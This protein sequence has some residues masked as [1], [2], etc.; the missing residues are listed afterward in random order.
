MRDCRAAIG[1]DERTKKQTKQDGESLSQSKVVVFAN[2]IHL[3]DLTPIILWPRM[4]EL[5]LSRIARLL[6][7]S[8]LPWPAIH[9]AGTNGK[10]SITG[11]LSALLTAAG[12]RC[13]SFTSPHLVDRWDCITINERVVQESVFRRIE[14]EVKRRN[15]SLGIGATEFELLT[16]TAFEIFS[17][18]KVDVGVVEV[19]MGGR[20]DSTNILTNVLVSIVAKIGYDHQA[21]LGD[22][23]QKIARE[24]AGIMKPAVPCVVDETNDPEVQEVFETV[25]KESHTSVSFVGAEV[26]KNAFPGLSRVFDELNVPPHQQANLSCAIAALQKV[27][28]Q[29]RPEL[30]LP[31]LFPHIPK[32]PRPG[33]LHELQL[34]PLIPR[35][36]PVLLDGAHNPQSAGVLGSYVD[37][38]LRKPDASVTW[39]I[40]ASQGKNVKELFGCMIKPGDNVAVLEF[41]PVDGMPWVRSVET[42]ALLSTVRSLPGIGQSEGFGNDI[43]SGLKWADKISMDGPLVIAGSLYLVSDILRLL[44]ESSRTSRTP[45]A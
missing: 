19:G 15:H 11:Y 23:I 35:K 17:H 42:S 38:N 33:R 32:I 12:V 41:G 20:L 18:E 43:L 26:I 9:V 21:M 22:T 45:S 30:S 6:Q 7:H 14:A 3:H 2:T 16:A 29:I 24:K 8:S 28:P 5:G 31:A 27:L 36:E 10:G 39:V 25:A 34:Q 40:A 13:G 37:R 1:R 4:I 44:R